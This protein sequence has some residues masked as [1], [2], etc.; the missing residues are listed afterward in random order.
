MARVLGLN[1]VFH[2]PAAALVV[3]GETIAAAEEERFS[4]RKHGKEP[5]PFSTWELPA[6][7]ARFCLD[8][9]G[10]D[11]TQ[12][13]AVT[14]SYDPML[15]PPLGDDVTADEFEGLR[16]L[17]AERAPR[18]LA[19]ALPGFDPDDVPVRARTTWPTR[20]R[21]T[22]PAPSPTRRCSYSTGGARPPRTWPAA[23][24]AATSRCCTPRACPTRWACSTRRSPSTSA[25]AGRATSTRSWRWPAT[26]TPTGSPRCCATPWPPTAR[27]GSG[28]DR[29]TSPRW[30]RTGRPA[31]RSRR[32][33]RRPGRRRP[34]AARGG[35]ARPGRLAACPHGRAGAHDGGRR[36]P[37]LR[38]ERPARGR[39]A[40]RAHL[41]AARRRR[42]RDRPGRGHGRGPRA[43]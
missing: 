40:L 18:F 43:G 2:D 19:T 7:A 39:G 12:V 34:D 5:V 24:D 9:A 16:T 28:S 11:I 20:A 36:G 22:W 27:A 21:P 13:D 26:A 31:S 1:A 41:G 17:F 38:G 25:S 3:D 32:L 30:R 35:A 23:R 8:R 33:T 6:A 42:R 14:Y 29:W 10:I 37:Q 15:A 4:R